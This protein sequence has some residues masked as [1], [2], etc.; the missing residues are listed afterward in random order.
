LIK[1]Y[2]H[3]VNLKAFAGSITL[4]VVTAGVIFGSAWTLNYWQAWTFLAAFF[5]SAF[6]ITIYLMKKDPKLLERRISAGPLHEKETSQKIIQS[7]AQASFLLVIIFPVL[8]HRFGWSTVPPYVNILGD[9]LVVI[10]FYIVFLVFK[11]NTFASALI[12]VRAEQKVISTG[13]YAR[14]RHPM[15]IGALIL[16]IGTPLSLGSLWGVLTIIPITVVIIWRLLDEERF[17]A[18]D[19]AGYV[20]YEERVTYRL[21]PFLW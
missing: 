19:L 10:G 14:V 20:E 15:Y 7:L 2:M 6:A 16:L 9:I 1:R 13:P 8:D 18:K 3:N 12:E 4:L 5:G 17:L 21:V 11:E